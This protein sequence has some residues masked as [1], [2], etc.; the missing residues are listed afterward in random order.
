MATV[1]RSL[2]ANL[3]FFAADNNVRRN[4]AT[5]SAS[6]TPTDGQQSLTYQT[7]NAGATFTVPIPASGSFIALG[8]TGPIRA[9]VT[10][11]QVTAGSYTRPSQGNIFIVNQVFVSDDKVTAMVLTNPQSYAVRVTIVQS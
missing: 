4:L 10:L 3:G 8:V 6:Y 7:L 2:A 1:I 5:F 9:D 11:G